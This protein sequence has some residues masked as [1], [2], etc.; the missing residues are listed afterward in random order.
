VLIAL[1][2][3]SSVALGARG[4]DAVKAKGA[5]VFSGGNLRFNNAQVW[6]RFVELAGGQGAPVVVVPSASAWPEK[7]GA[8]VAENLK[9]Y[10][11]RAEIVLIAP[12]AH[13]GDYRQA[14][15]DPDNVKKLRGARGI[16]FLGGEQERITQALVNEDGSKTPALEAIWDAYRAGAVLGGSSAG[17]AVMSRWMFAD[18]RESLGTLQFGI[19]KKAVQAGLGFIGDDWF[20]DQHFLARGRFARTLRAMHQYGYHHGIGVDEDSAVVYKDGV[21]HVIGYKGAVVLDI[22]GVYV[23]GKLADFNMKKARLDYLDTG[24]SLDARTHKVTVSQRKTND[25]KIDPQA[26]SFRPFYGDPAPMSDILAPW[27]LYK[28]MCEALDSRTGMV[29]GLAFGLSGARKELGFEVKVYRGKDTIGWNTVLGG[30]DSYTVLNVYVDI[31][32]V[33]MADPLYQPRK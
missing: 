27:Q 8:D 5:L 14:A 11:A 24:D 32:P 16:W 31:T 7:I 9:K 30:N 2:V 29:T 15:R 25:R 18:A 17:A 10:G 21:F 19:D 12:R 13:E 20:V 6:Q 23:D 1:A 22:T 28:A 3:V 4:D 26:G 33:R